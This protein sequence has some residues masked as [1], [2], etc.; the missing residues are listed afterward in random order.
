MATGG[1]GGARGLSSIVNEL[2]PLSTTISRSRC[3][4]HICYYCYWRIE[5]SS[6]CHHDTGIVW[7]NGCTANEEDEIIVFVILFVIVAVIVEK[8]IAPLPPRPL[9]SNVS[10]WLWALTS[11]QRPRRL[12]HHCRC[13]HGD[14]IPSLLNVYSLEFSAIPPPIGEDNETIIVV[15]VESSKKQQVQ[16]R[17]PI[18]GPPPSFP[19]RNI[20]HNNSG[21]IL[22]E[23]ALGSPELW[24]QKSRVNGGG[25]NSDGG[26]GGSRYGGG[27]VR[28]SCCQAAHHVV[29]VVFFVIRGAMDGLGRV[30]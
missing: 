26:G 18:S 17:Q 5:L 16:S 10:Q 6:I 4:P 8:V 30:Q 28:Q 3:V 2:L 7:D 22:S 24:W 25:K 20:F 1:G 12:R 15:V 23:S 19:Q 11:C 13:L 9:F 14:S 29:V 27:S 21:M